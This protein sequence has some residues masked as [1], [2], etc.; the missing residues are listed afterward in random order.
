MSRVVK[1]KL[2]RRRNKKVAENTSGVSKRTPDE[3]LCKDKYE[4]HLRQPGKRII[5]NVK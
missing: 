4:Q 1:N 2:G 5:Q 3:K